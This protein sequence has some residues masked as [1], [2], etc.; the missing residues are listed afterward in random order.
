MP[1]TFFEILRAL[2]F[3]LAVVSS[4]SLCG[5]EGAPGLIWELVALRTSEECERG[6]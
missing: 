1:T 2:A 6:P 4:G 3:L 5:F